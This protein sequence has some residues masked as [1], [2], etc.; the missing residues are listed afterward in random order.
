[1]YKI[2]PTVIGAWAE[3]LREANQARLL[4]GNRELKSLCNQDFLLRQFQSLGV[5]RDPH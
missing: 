5:G 4:L 1:M 2:T 3:I